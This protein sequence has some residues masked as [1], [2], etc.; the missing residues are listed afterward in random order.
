MQQMY[1]N[2]CLSVYIGIGS[3]YKI[4]LLLLNTTNNK[5]GI[6]PIKRMMKKFVREINEEPS[7]GFKS[8]YAAC[9]TLFV[10]NKNVTKVLNSRKSI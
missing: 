6:I 2:H 4:V 10:L 7:A 1:K 9:L 8:I 3:R 5:L